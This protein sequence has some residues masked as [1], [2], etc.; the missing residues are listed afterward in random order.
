MSCRLGVVFGD[1]GLFIKRRLQT[2]LA[3]SS[4]STFKMILIT[5]NV[6]FADPGHPKPVCIA[7]VSTAGILH[8][9]FIHR[10]FCFSLVIVRL[11]C[12]LDIT[13]QRII[14]ASEA[15]KADDPSI[16]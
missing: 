10:Q 12:P 3:K 11:Y 9:S 16:Y 4:D 8:L 14:N 1:Y 13:V 15:R 6:V 2:H 5:L 7:I